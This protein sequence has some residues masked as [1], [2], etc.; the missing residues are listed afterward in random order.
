MTFDIN[1]MPLNDLQEHYEHTHCPCNPRVEVIGASLLIVHN[2][3]D[4]RE[5]AEQL[6]EEV[7]NGQTK[8]D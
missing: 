5:I 8:Y 2:S 7:L 4:H 3:Y 6:N 1:V